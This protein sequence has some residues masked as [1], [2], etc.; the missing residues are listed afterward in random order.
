MLKEVAK[1]AASERYLGIATRRLLQHNTA[2]LHD[3]REVERRSA[4]TE[5]DRLARK[6]HRRA[7][8]AARHRH[9]SDLPEQQVGGRS[10]DR[11]GHAATV[12]QT[13]FQDELRR[14]GDERGGLRWSGEVEERRGERWQEIEDEHGGR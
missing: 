9:A 1:V 2:L 5:I 12:A 13:R 7:P 14:A 8:A 3:L 10:V 11:H 6:P 4:N